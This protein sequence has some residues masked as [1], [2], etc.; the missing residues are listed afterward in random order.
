MQG[1]RAL[2][3][4]KMEN[5]SKRVYKKR[6][7]VLKYKSNFFNIVKI[8][9]YNL[10]IHSTSFC[11]LRTINLQLKN[12]QTLMTSLKS[13]RIQSVDALRGFAIVAI[14]LLH[15]TGSIVWVIIFATKTKPILPETR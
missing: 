4:N 14:L 13:P 9:K 7:S 5:K 6:E 3:D 1:N 15:N 2:F 8:C 10:V 11:K 12:T